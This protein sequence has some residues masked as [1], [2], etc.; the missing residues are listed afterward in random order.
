MNPELSP[1]IGLDAVNL[2]EVVQITISSD[3]LQK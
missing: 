1:A 2:L 3:I